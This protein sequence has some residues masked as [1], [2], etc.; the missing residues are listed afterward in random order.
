[1]FIWKVDSPIF[2]SEYDRCFKANHANLLQ[3]INLLQTTEPVK[4]TTRSIW[5]MLGPF[6]TASRRYI[7]SHQVLLVARQL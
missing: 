7:V 6:A 1:M 3:L 5:K 2:R 4:L